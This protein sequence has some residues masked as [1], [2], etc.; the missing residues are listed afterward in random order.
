[1][2]R[3]RFNE[4]A[5]M[6]FNW[7]RPF[8]L[9]AVVDL[10]THL[11]SHLPQTP[12]VF[13]VRGCKGKIKYFLGVDRKLKRIITD[14]MKAHGNIRFAEA[15]KGARAA[16][17][18]ASQL[19]ISKPTLSLKTN[20][21]EACIRAG[22]AALNQAK[23]EEQAVLQVVLGRPLGPRPTP[24]HLPDPHACWVS[25]AL[26]KADEATAEAKLLM[27]EK[28]SSPAF[29]A[30]VRMGASG[31][32]KSGRGLILSLLSAFRT[33][34]SGGVSIKM[35][36]EKPSRLS[37]AYIPWHFPL[38]L[39]VKELAN[40]LLLPAGD[41]ELPG[42][43]G[44]HPKQI[45][46]PSW[47]R[48][49][50]PVH[51][52]TF[53]NSPDEKYK[54]SISPKDSLEHTVILGSTGSG[55]STVMQNL[56]LK[57][58]NAGR[59]VLVIDP[60]ADLVNAVIARI[61][62]HRENDVVIIDPSSPCP[63]GFNPLSCKNQ[64][65]PG[66]AADAMLAVF[67][68]V[69]K[70]NWGI[71]SQEHIAA[72][73]LTLAQTKGASLLWL[74]TLLTNEEFRRKITSAVDD[75]IGLEPYWA[76]FEAMSAAERRKEI[77][78]VL[79]KVRQF[80]L[81]PGLRNILGQSSPKFDMNELFTSRK[82]VLVPLNKGLIGSESAKLLGS[83][84]VGLTWTLAL[85]RAGLPEEKR[86]P[87]SLYIDELQDYIAS[88]AKDFTDALA[89]ARG[90]GVGITMAHQYRVQLPKE[91]QAGVDA[92]AK[93]KICFGLGS[94]DAKAMAE[95]APELTAEDFMALP[96]YHVYASFKSEGKNTGWLSG[97]TPPESK[98]IRNET[99][100]K[101]K[102]AERY[103]KPRHEVEQEYLDLLASCHTA[104]EP[105]NVKV[106]VGR[107][108]KA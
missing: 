29:N 15:P 103:G 8:E 86:T 94:S 42:T 57:D 91:I 77:A 64:K 23:G 105:K 43:A 36:R 30:A 49:P 46:P 89:Q 27:K 106:P 83:L 48:N 53:A 44:L 50:F 76:E 102:V 11:A 10:L 97:I 87:V 78:P 73:L 92:N 13:E 35:T 59:S 101:G 45:H 21:S 88:I 12:I 68:E 26:G 1:M 34:R 5:W 90:L 82:I 22:L 9:K 37:K 58:I 93:N 67:Q 4:L 84:I 99:V 96:P 71:R 55:K 28:M 39:S 95:M 24:S 79:N 17:N 62:K 72:G 47:Y 19:K 108:R 80:L 60:K 65:N 6:T 104:N 33:L 100:F 7:Q 70:E 38:R 51:D 85:G 56:I 52:R 61:P 20:T 54:L 31:T 63:V 107:R 2:K 16:V 40:F 18:V 41:T 69:F 74:P 32:V 81:R 75:K 14:V 66:L 98:A 25:I 3:T